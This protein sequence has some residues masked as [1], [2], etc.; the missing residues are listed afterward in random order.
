MNSDKN[1]LFIDKNIL[2]FGLGKSG[3]SSLK[4]LA[5]YCKSI[6]ALDNNPD[7]ALPEDFIEL[8]ENNEIKFFIGSSENFI[9]NLLDKIDLIIVSPGISMGIPLLQKALRKKI[10]IWSELELAWVFMNEKQKKN[11]IA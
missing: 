2:I 4:K 10:K 6:S 5:G 1:S 3:L 11:T 9:N 7:F 8:S